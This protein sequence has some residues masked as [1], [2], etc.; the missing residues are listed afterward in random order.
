VVGNVGFLQANIPLIPDA[1]PDDGV[2]DL[3]VASPRRAADWVRLTAQ[4][5]AR[6][7]RPDE[8]LDRL[9]GR[10]VQVSVEHPDAYQMDGDT[11]GTC[12]SMT[13]EVV[14]GALTLRVPRSVKRALEAAEQPEPGRADTLV[15]AGA[16]EPARGGSGRRKGQLRADPGGDG[17]AGQRRRSRASQ[18]AA[19]A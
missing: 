11:V 5:L 17:R 6:R 2:I 15:L 18:A 7:H 19:S 13:F 8:Q 10:R 14:P 12:T 16:T 3:L 1:Q 4:V 9:A